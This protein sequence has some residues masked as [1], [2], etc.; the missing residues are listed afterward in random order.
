MTRVGSVKVLVVGA[1]AREHALARCLAQDPGVSEV[2]VG[3][4]GPGIA[5]LTP[6]LPEL[7]DP[8][9]S[10]AVVTA[11][12]R[13]A[14]DLVVIGPEAPLVAGVAD[15]VRA[16]GIA[17]FGP[18]AAAARLESS[19]AFA[20]EVMAAA[21]VPTARAH[22]CTGIDDVAEALDSTGPPYVVKADGLAGG[23]GVVVDDDLEVALR[24]AR[25]CL[26]KPGG[27]VVVEEFLDGPEVSLFC[28]TDGY[29]VR[30]LAPA[31]DFKRLGDGDTGPN[32]GGMGAYSPLPWLEEQV[33]DLV[34]TVLE[35]IAEPTVA[36][37]RHRGVPFV[38]V[39]YVGL[40]L[41]SRGPRVVEFNARFGDP[42]TQSVLA[43]LRTPLGSLLHAAATGRLQELPP[44][45]WHPESAVTV[46]LAA[47]GYPDK[48]V[49][50]IPVTGFD[51]LAQVPDT[52][53]L[54]AGTAPDPDPEA[55]RGALVSSGG[56]VL[57]VVSLGA[58]LAQARD[59]A[60]AAA[61]L[62]EMAG[63]QRRTD[64]ALAAARGEVRVP[65]VVPHGPGR[66][67]HPVA[68]NG[69]RAEIPGHVRVY[70]GKVRE[71]FAPVEERTG[72]VRDDLLLLVASD[73]V[74]AY[75]H[76]LDS[77][78]PD[79]GAVLTMLSLWWCDRL[80]D[81]VPHH[82]QS[83]DV[84][85]AVAGRGVYVRRLRMLPI[86]A[87][88]RAYLTGGGLK[89]YRRDGTVSGVPLPDGLVDGSRLPEPVFTPST[90][91]ALGE[92]DQPM[93]YDEVVCV[94]G[95]ALA[96]RVR[97]LTLAILRR[98]NEIAEGRGIL[99]ADTKVEFGVDPVALG[100]PPGAEVDWSALDPDTIQLVL[101]DEVL[102]PDSS[103]FWRAE[104][105]APGSA[106]TSYDKQVLRDWLTGPHSG[107]DP[108][109]AD[110]PPALPEEVVTLTRAR[111]VE[112]YE[113]LTGGSFD[114]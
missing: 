21:D 15:A 97:D 12:R 49:S 19:K 22:I 1:G 38:G 90:K 92:H 109:S 64:I 63:S 37:M 23:K 106:Q 74:S 52:H 46:V 41:T 40:A 70:S 99:I 44:L 69:D 66:D 62:I 95:P 72:A 6:C 111:Y 100:V 85:A 76:V 79:K 45:T 31:Q 20:K 82:V 60:Y 113:A 83:T 3:P 53:V 55:A 42:E 103:R 28:V 4:G 59:R 89:E 50:G 104:E 47:P 8:T 11:A 10:V 13:H 48:P 32:T 39:L 9:D 34:R 29:A 18:S 27:A 58:D 51:R 105:W 36:E 110:P 93:T 14:V 78:V 68:P 7:A 57:S 33:P 91:A 84:P 43:R 17:C 96:A 108:S 56:R 73:R 80:A 35:R 71:L 87:I 61:D 67:A 101:A 16:A 77:P 107:W 81:L 24:H 54:H 112:A 30:A 2:L 5:A 26:G 75:D 25:S 65:D 102:T 94:L 98:G 88:A 114:R 86:E